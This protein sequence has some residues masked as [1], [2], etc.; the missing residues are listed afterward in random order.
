MTY[1]VATHNGDAPVL[2]YQYNNSNGVLL[3]N[4]RIE[5]TTRFV[6]MVVQTI[7]IFSRFSVYYNGKLQE[8][9][10]CVHLY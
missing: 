2:G 3:N 10:T 9:S 4:R 8:L 1:T 6:M 7:V 5:Y